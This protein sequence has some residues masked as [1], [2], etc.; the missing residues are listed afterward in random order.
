[1]YFNNDPT[2]AAIRDART[3]LDLLEARG[4]AA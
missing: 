4:V 3:L 2:G 1:V